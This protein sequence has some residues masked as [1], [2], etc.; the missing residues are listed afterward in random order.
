LFIGKGSSLPALD[1]SSNDSFFDLD[2]SEDCYLVDHILP[3]VTYPC[4]EEQDEERQ[5]H[6]PHILGSVLSIKGFLEERLLADLHGW[7]R[8][9]QFKHYA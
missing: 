1:R 6:S 3:S 8:S 4:K 2:I 5:T 9:N 7:P